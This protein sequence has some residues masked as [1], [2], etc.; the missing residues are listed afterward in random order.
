MRPSNFILKSPAAIVVS[1][2]ACLAFLSCSDWIYKPV[3]FHTPVPPPPPNAFVSKDSL[4]ALVGTQNVKLAYTKMITGGTQMLYFVDFNDSSVTPK[5]LKKPGD[6]QDWSAS[7]PIISPDGALVA[8]YLVDPSNIKHAAAYCQKLDTSAVPNLIDDPGSDPH[9]FK[10]INNNLFITYA[11]TTDEVDATYSM[12]TTKHTYRV[13][14]SAGTGAKTGTRDSI[15]PFPF[16]GGMS[17]D[18]AY[19]CTGY[20]NAYIFNISTQNFFSVDT[21]KQTCNPSMTPDSLLTGRMMFLNIGGI[22]NLST[23]GALA[24][25]AFREHQYVLIADT[26]NN[27]VGS[28]NVDQIL[29]DYAGGEWQCPKWT[30]A[31]NFFC[32]L[33]TKSTAAS[34]V[35]YDCFIVSIVPTKTLLLNVKPDLLQFN[36]TS[37]PYVYIGGK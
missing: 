11:D 3:Q 27:L 18:G 23:M 17:Y 20:I 33:A 7:C 34:T 4:S 14:I 8:Y 21:G 36:S 12:L 5:L 25:A 13:Q 15:A 35:V 28:F 16:Y 2:F 31:S 6:K 30:N 26:G 29:P 32:A 22:Q 10:D 1:A 37:K 19:I 24:G 9:F